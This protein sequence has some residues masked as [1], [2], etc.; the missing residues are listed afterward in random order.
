[1]KTITEGELTPTIIGVADAT[2]Y[3]VGRLDAKHNLVGLSVSE[4]VATLNSLV[5]AKEF[6]R[7]RHISSALLE[8][9]SAYDEMC[10]NEGPTRVVER[11]NI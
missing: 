9:Q 6:L 2:H 8:F 10:G 1:M 4:D 5:E 7:E 11:I 3:L